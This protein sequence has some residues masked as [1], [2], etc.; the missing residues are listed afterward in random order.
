MDV[1]TKVEAVS[2]PGGKVESARV[3]SK[4][5]TE[6]KCELALS[7]GDWTVRIT[8][9]TATIDVGQIKIIDT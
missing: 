4:I 9:G 5:P 3:I 1:V 2:T 7:A 8:S 6:I